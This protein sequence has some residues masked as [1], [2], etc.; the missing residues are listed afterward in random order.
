METIQ[1]CL[2]QP[3]VKKQGHHLANRLS[4]EQGT[5]EQRKSLNRKENVAKGTNQRW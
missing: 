4:N 1:V 2:W 3:L 5:Q